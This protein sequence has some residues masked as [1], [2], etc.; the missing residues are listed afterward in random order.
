MAKVKT[1]T[2]IL[3]RLGIGG[4]KAKTPSTRA[5]KRAL[6]G[7]RKFEPIA[8]AGSRKPG[9]KIGE[10]VPT[11]GKGRATVK[12]ITPSIKKITPPIKAK[13]KVSR[14]QGRK[15]PSSTAVTTTQSTPVAKK[16]GTSLVPIGSSSRAVTGGGTKVGNTMKPATRTTPKQITNKSGTKTPPPKTKNNNLRN[17]LHLNL[18]KVVRVV[19]LLKK[20][21]LSIS[22]VMQVLNELLLNLNLLVQDL[23]QALVLKVISFRGLLKN[24]LDI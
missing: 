6:R 21:L 19:L 18:V 11:A 15:K 20:L 22:R 2:E 1:L 17:H 4:V 5:G 23:I 3:K 16:P 7:A 12:K 24:V 13:P 9:R 8:G 10:D 14:T